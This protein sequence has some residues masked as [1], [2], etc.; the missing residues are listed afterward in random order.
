MSDPHNFD[1]DFE[2]ATVA[3]ERMLT[4]LR[5]ADHFAVGRRVLAV[6]ALTQ[7][8]PLARIMLLGLTARAQES[9]AL[10]I[11]RQMIAGMADEVDQEH[12]E[13]G[14]TFGNTLIP[15]AMQS[16]WEPTATFASAIAAALPAPTE[17]GGFGAWFSDRLDQIVAA[18]PMATEVGTPKYLA[19]FLVRLAKLQKGQSIL[20]P[21]CGLGGLLSQAFQSADDLHLVGLEVHPISQALATLRLALLDAN[22]RVLL[23][24]ALGTTK[25]EVFDR[26]LCD[27]PLGYYAPPGEDT[28]SVRN[29]AAHGVLRRM[30][31]L[32]LERSLH[33]ISPSGRAVVL[34][35]QGVLTRRGGDYELRRRLLAEGVLEAIIG[36]PA[37]AIPWTGV[38]L[39]ILVLSRECLHE[40]VAVFDGSARGTRSLRGAQALAWVSDAYLRRDP[41]SYREVPYT[42]LDPAEGFLP[43]RIIGGEIMRPNADELRAGARRLFQSA[44]ERLPRI[45]RLF[46]DVRRDG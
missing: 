5:A 30:D 24:D 13:F 44:E 20:D 31:A 27:P 16:R 3:F 18:G 6:V 2:S 26:V 46:D 21:C 39:A 38:E 17:E 22:A 28:R 41:E 36:L 42:E 14:G 19:S 9:S 15:D 1:R 7:F 43:R 8:H 45:M 40:R 23:E 35:S 12:P 37:S 33:S 34:V 25:V 10:E 32:F 29:R 4:R 11:F